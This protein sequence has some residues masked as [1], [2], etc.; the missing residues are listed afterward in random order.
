VLSPW[1]HNIATILERWT[2]RQLIENNGHYAKMLEL[3]AGF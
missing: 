1:E 3:Q 2:H